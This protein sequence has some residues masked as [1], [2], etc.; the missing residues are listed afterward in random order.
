M[1]TATILSSNQVTILTTILIVL[2][3][4][5][6]GI[7]PQDLWQAILDTLVTTDSLSSIIGGTPQKGIHAALTALAEK[8]FLSYLSTN[9]HKIEVKEAF[10]PLIL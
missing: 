3:V 6:D 5:Y 9:K 1:D 2:V 7:L 4:G 10:Y 8:I